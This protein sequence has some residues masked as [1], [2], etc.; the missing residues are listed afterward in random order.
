VAT[1]AGNCD[2]LIAILERPQERL[3]ID[4]SYLE[5]NLGEANIRVER[6]A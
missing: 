2:E 4:H 3:I 1:W 6:N 5:A